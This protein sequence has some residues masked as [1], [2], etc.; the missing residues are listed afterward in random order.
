MCSTR[1]VELIH[2]FRAVAIDFDQLLADK[3]AVASLEQIIRELEA[4]QRMIFFPIILN[5]SG[6]G[7][8]A[9]KYL[10]MANYVSRANAA[11][12]DLRNLLAQ[13]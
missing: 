2:F 12:I 13:G 3:N 7:L 6:F 9:N 5:E 1:P 10:T 8:F 4:S 11:I